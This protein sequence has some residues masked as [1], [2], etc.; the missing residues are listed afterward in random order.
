MR[1][2]QL[3][4]AAVGAGVLIATLFAGHALAAQIELAATFPASRLEVDTAPTTLK[5]PGPT[6]V[7]AIVDDWHGATILRVLVAFAILGGPNKGERLALAS[8]HK[9]GPSKRAYAKRAEA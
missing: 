7:T 2:V 1:R 9:D 4:A 8:T 6:T 3:A 5:M